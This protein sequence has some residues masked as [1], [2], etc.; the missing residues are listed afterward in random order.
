[1]LYLS[2]KMDLASS[3]ITACG[4]AVAITVNFVLSEAVDDALSFF[5]VPQAVKPNANVAAA[6]IFVIL[7]MSFLPFLFIYIYR[8][9]IRFTIASPIHCIANTMTIMMMVEV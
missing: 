7:F 8:L 5:D 1:M 3:R 9:S 6:I 4:L 2:F